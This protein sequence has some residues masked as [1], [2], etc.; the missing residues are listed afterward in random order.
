[1]RSEPPRDYGPGCSELARVRGVFA[2]ARVMD[3][4]RES[5]S[6]LLRMSHGVNARRAAHAHDASPSA[7]PLAL[8]PEADAKALHTVAPAVPREREF[9]EAQGRHAS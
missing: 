2:S 7:S 4:P 6:W 5:W 9:Q 1:M 8:V 3:C